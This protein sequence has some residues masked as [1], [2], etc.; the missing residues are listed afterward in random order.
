[1]E[2]RAAELLI[3]TAAAFPPRN[4]ARVLFCTLPADMIAKFCVITC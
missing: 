1:M 2:K 3:R 4:Y